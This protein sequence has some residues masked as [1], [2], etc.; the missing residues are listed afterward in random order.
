L[1]GQKTRRLTAELNG[2]FRRVSDGRRGE[3]EEDVAIADKL[4]NFLLSEPA[5]DGNK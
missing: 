1:V 2:D 5:G 4:C 3:K